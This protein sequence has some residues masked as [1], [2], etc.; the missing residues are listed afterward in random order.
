MLRLVLSLT[1]LLIG[2]TQPQ[3]FALEDGR[4]KNI[5]TVSEISNGRRRVLV[6]HDELRHN[7]CY[8]SSNGLFC[9]ADRH[10]HE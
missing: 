3:Q 9:L 4:E 7:T 6:F 2:C 8:T 5:G 10:A 1:V